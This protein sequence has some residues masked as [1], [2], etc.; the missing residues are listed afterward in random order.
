MQIYAADTYADIPERK[1]RA[2]DHASSILV[3]VGLEGRV[4][5]DVDDDTAAAPTMTAPTMRR[6]KAAAWTPPPW[7]PRAPLRGRPLFLAQFGGTV[8][9]N[10]A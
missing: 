2:A 10:W 8:V 3:P 5:A 1:D 9:V 4:F 7:R 6:S